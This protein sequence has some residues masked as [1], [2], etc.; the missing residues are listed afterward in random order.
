MPIYET[1]EYRI[2]APAT[3]KVKQAIDEFVHY[4]KENEPGT[5]LYMAWQ[6][7]DDPARF[8]HLFIFEDAAAQTRHSESDAVKRFEATYGPELLGGDVV[9]TDF[10]LVAANQSIA[11]RR[12]DNGSAYRVQHPRSVRRRPAKP[13]ATTAPHGTM[14]SWQYGV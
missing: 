9:F 5:R 8:L 13:C 12:A 4:V 11:A 7:K 1:A 3:G 2:N 14:L 10:E 6:Q